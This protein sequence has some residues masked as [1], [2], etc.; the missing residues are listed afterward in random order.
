[1]ANQVDDRHPTAVAAAMPDA[2][3]FRAAIGPVRQ[4]PAVAAPPTAPKPPPRAH[5]AE[6]D[7]RRARGEL[8]HMLETSRIEAEPNLSWRC[9]DVPMQA[10]HRLR[11]GL[12]VVQAELDLRSDVAA[13]SSL[14]RFLRQSRRQ[15]LGC[16]RLLHD[17]DPTLKLALDGILRR[18]AD[19]AAFHS[20]PATRAGV[21]ATLVLLRRP[22][23]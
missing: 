20:A 15:A 19:I 7:E 5:M 13:V 18:R 3:L 8:A 10:L 22:R 6:R 9:D 17:D 16:V 4:L 21:G 1:M 12:Y 14:R 2:D 11:H 23:R